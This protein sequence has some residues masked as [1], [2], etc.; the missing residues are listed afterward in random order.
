MRIVVWAA[1]GVAAVILLF[2][3]LAYGPGSLQA[4]GFGPNA[5]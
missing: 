5:S 2:L 3:L 1:G 4:Q